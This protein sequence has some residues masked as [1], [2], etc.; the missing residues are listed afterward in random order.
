MPNGKLALNLLDFLNAYQLTTGR[1]ECVI[2]NAAEVFGDE[3][4]DLKREEKLEKCTK[5][6]N[7]I[8]SKKLS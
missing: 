4:E 3:S 5:L 6:M 2:E 1:S 7:S 8:T